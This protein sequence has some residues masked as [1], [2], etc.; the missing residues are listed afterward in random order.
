MSVLDGE[1]NKKMSVLSG[2]NNKKMSVSEEENRKKMSV[3]IKL[4]FV[5]FSNAARGNPKKRGKKVRNGKNQSK[6][7]LSHLSLI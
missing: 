1:N 2:E 4:G 5:T 7:D 3:S 6:S